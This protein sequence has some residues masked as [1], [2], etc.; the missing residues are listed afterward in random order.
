VIAA[1]QV[2]LLHVKIQ[3]FGDGKEVGHSVGQLAESGFVLFVNSGA[4]LRQFL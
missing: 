1:V 3:N 2:D 4:N